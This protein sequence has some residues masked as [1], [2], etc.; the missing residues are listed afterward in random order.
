M[1]AHVTRERWGF[2]RGALVIGGVMLEKV[3]VSYIR[4]GVG[5]I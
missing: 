5:F 1:F 3:T 4:G 2:R